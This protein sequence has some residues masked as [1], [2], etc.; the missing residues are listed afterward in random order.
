MSIRRPLC[1]LIASAL[2][3]TALSASADE[4]AGRATQRRVALRQA[5]EAL[6]DKEWRTAAQALNT[7]RRSHKGTP[8][9][10]EAWV[11]EAGALL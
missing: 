11:L 2:L 5:E 6:R 9:A 8:E 7:F 1:L 4:A 10:L 3:V